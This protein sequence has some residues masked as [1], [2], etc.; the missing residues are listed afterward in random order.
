MGREADVRSRRQARSTRRISLGLVLQ[1][2]VS[3][4]W[5]HLREGCERFVSEGNLP[6]RFRRSQAI[7][8]RLSFNPDPRLPV[9]SFDDLG[10]RWFR[11]ASVTR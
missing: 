8:E 6:S 10:R 11:A 7:R 3:V 1:D 2:G 5:R 9:G 4:M